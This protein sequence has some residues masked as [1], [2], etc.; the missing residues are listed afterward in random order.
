MNLIFFEKEKD[1]I[2]IFSI[3]ISSHKKGKLYLQAKRV[4]FTF[5][6]FGPDLIVFI[7]LKN[8]KNE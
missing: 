7:Y 8:K 2:K 4:F 1:R 6:F 5:C 3:K